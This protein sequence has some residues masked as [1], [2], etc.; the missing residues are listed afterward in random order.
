M[1]RHG[2]IKP[3]AVGPQLSAMAPRVSMAITDTES[4]TSPVAVTQISAL[5]GNQGSQFTP[6][7]ESADRGRPIPDTSR[8]SK[9]P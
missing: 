4:V 8:K 9:S 1:T 7:L 3:P 2:M 5:A 6:V